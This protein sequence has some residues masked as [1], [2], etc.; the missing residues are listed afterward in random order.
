MPFDFLSHRET[1]LFHF[2]P[3]L[4]LAFVPQAA[5]PVGVL[6]FPRRTAH[7]SAPP[8][9]SWPAKSPAPPTHRQPGAKESTVSC[10]HA[11]LS[12]GGCPDRLLGPVARPPRPPPKLDKS[13]R[14]LLEPR[15]KPSAGRWGATEG[16]RKGA[17][18][19]RSLPR[20][21]R[22]PPAA[23]RS[24]AEGRRNRSAARRNP[25]EGRRSLKNG[26]A[27]RRQGVGEHRPG[28]ARGR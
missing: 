28:V 3:N 14:N 19:R 12:A 23:R 20:G 15:R 8:A 4:W 24:R 13:R 26:V 5:A 21:R 25:P 16:R 27:G 22:S 11:R 7:S 17:K 18:G 1:R 10:G 2:E 6:E 9:R